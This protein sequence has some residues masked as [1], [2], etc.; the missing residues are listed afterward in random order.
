[1]AREVHRYADA[2]HAERLAGRHHEP[3]VQTAVVDRGA[4]A[5]PELEAAGQARAE[6][7]RSVGNE[8]AL[9]EPP[10]Q[11]HLLDAEPRS[12]RAAPGLALEAPA[13]L[14][15]TGALPLRDERP[16][17]ARTAE[18]VLVDALAAIA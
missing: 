3:A 2:S 11:E 18:V 7:E 13:D 16:A 17:E 15:Q 6:D 9:I 1:R 8:P 12:A 14:G 10:D 4:R 5:E